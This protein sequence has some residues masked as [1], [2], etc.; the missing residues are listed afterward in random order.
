M[1]PIKVLFVC[2]HNSARSQ[3]AEAYVN[4][5]AA[6]T[7]AAQSAGLTPGKLNPVVVSLMKEVGIDI[8][9]HGTKSVEDFIKR[10]ELFDYVIT[11]CDE[12]SAER[13]PAFPGKAKK[14]HWGF[15]DPSSFK[16]TEDEKIARTRVIRDQIKAKV[17]Q[18]IQ[19]LASQGCDP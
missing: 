7:L 8:S 15:E 10:K 12:A 11:V 6:G 5:L 1:A 18:W 13:C 16:G 3:M 9:G 14:L 19:T 2:I 17:S 4:R